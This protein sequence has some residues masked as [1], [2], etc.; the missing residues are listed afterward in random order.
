MVELGYGQ[1]EYITL[2]P[3]PSL[4]TYVTTFHELMSVVS[5]T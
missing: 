4:P 1:M 2:N 5:Q 3:L